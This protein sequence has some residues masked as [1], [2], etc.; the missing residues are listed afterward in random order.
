MVGYWWRQQQW[1]CF[2]GRRTRRVI[3]QLEVAGKQVNDE[4]QIQRRPG[5]NPQHV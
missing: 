3:V 1:V 2:I 5:I 4:A